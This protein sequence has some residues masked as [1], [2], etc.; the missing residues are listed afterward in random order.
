MVKYEQK[1]RVITVPHKLVYAWVVSLICMITVAGLAIQYA[2]YVD[3]KSNQRWCGVVT[4]L[5]DAYT[6]NPPQTPAGKE[7]AWEM[8]KLKTE[9]RCR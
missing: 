4:L 8:K 1:V 7:L 2:N 3:R 5:D 6:A 9:F